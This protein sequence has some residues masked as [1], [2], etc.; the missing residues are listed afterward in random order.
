MDRI[1]I[2]RLA[3]LHPLIRERALAAFKKAHEALKGG[4]QP[5]IT[6]AYRTDAEQERLYTIGRTEPPYGKY[7]THARAGQSYHN[8]GLAVDFVLL[9]RD[10][11]HISWDTLKDFD[12]D[13]KSDW[14]EVVEIFKDDGWQWGGDFRTFKDRP[15]LQ[16][17]LGK[18]IADLQK[19]AKF[20][21]VVG[22]RKLTYPKVS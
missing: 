6:Y 9:S 19:A 1:S 8:Y 18:T 15:H 11:K 21:E 7:V 22:A 3:E 2:E 10:G 17:T 20:S 14:M 4:F 12:G 5:R 16:L 13:L